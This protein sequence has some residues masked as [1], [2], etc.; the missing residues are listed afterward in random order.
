MNNHKTRRQL[1]TQ[2][3]GKMLDGTIHH[4]I[5]DDPQNEQ[6]SDLE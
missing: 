2:M 3:G 5:D 6:A 1:E 4:Y